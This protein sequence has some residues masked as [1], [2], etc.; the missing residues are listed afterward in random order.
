MI[1]KREPRVARI[2]RAMR[3][4]SSREFVEETGQAKVTLANK[5]YEV[6]VRSDIDAL[7]M[8]TFV[9]PAPRIGEVHVTFP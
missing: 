7:I 4:V 5:I 8:P 3:P 9:C 2:L 1:K 6:F